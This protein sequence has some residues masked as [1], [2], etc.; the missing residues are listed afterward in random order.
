MR[1]EW[2]FIW[3]NLNPHHRRM[4][5]VKFSW[6]WPS[7]S[8]DEDFKNFVNVFSL[9]RYYFP[10]EKGWALQLNKFEASSPKVALCQV[11]LKLAGGSGE[12]FWISLMYRYFVIISP[13]K[14]ARPFIWTN[15]SLHHPIMLWAKFGW[16]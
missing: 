5:C 9:I 10:S 13:S 3:T 7:G 8:G 4:L 11:W 16:N 12:D 15:S 6:N 1:S 2:F 14:R